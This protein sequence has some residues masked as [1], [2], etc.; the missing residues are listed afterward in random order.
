MTMRTFHT[1]GV[2]RTDITQGLPRVEELFEAR[3]PKAEADVATVSGKVVVETAE[4]DSKTILIVGKKKQIR[5]V[6]VS[7]AKKISVTDGA[8]V[9]TGQV[10][11][12]DAE[13][14]E[15]QAPFDGEVVLQG[16]ILELSGE[17]SAEETVTVVPGVTVMV[18][19]GDEITAGTQLTGGSIDPKVLA[20]TIDMTA[21]QTYI[22]DEI[23]KVFNEQGISVADIHLEVIIRQMARLGR[24][25]NSG[26]NDPIVV[27]SLVNRFRLEATNKKLL[28]DG[29]NKALIVPMLMGIKT[30]ALYTE[31]FLSAMSFEQQVKVLTDAA[32]L[33]KIDKLRGMKE[34]VMIGRRVPSGEEAR[35]NMESEVEDILNS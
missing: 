22:L 25:I 26:D 13:G 16:G 6:V 32:I 3:T 21:A 23:Q 9:K 35:I 34:N 12:I 17:V 24:V 31:S 29:K 1:G 11:Y 33:G 30:S 18:A 8:K 2:Q 15:K 10:M 27:G 5:R 20:E 19:D 4:D 14:S 7:D 28:A